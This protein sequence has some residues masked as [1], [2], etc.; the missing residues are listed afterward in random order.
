MEDDRRSKKMVAVIHCVINHNARDEGWAMY[1]GI[2]HE[3]IDILEK[4]GAG[5]IQMPCPEM[6][7]LGLPRTRPVGDSI[8]KALDT[9]QG[10]SH[11]QELAHS[12]AETIAE[13]QRNGYKVAAILGGDVESPGCAVPAATGAASIHEQ[14]GGFGIFTKALMDELAVMEIQI[15]IRGIRDSARETLMED[16]QWLDKTLASS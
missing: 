13:F 6:S 12:V 1:P 9:P 11:C 7:A 4:H 14:R 3:V 5:V 8:L 15:P 10:R 16:L 2:N